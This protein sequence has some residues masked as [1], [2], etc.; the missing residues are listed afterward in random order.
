MPHMPE[1]G[2]S[3]IGL[4]IVLI[5]IG[6]GLTVSPKMPWLGRL[7][8]DIVIKKEGFLLYIPITSCILIGVVVSLVMRIFRR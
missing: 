2:K 3:L 5:A 6:I 7:P 8:G 4:G 1:A